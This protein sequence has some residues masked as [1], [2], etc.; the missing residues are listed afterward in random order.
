MSETWI[1]RMPIADNG[2]LDALRLRPEIDV[3]EDGETLWLRMTLG[4]DSK[5]LS[6]LLRSLPGKHY[7]LRNACELI[8]FGRRTPDGSLPLLPWTKLQDW[9]Q[10]ELPTT[11]FS[12]QITGLVDLR[13]VRSAVERDARL[14]MTTIEAWQ[15]YVESAPQIRLTPLSF[16]MNGKTHVLVRGIPLPPIPGQRF[17]FEGNI[18]LPLG[19]R[20]EPDIDP[21][22][23]VERLELSN[24]DM[25]VFQ[26]SGMW[27]HVR[28]DEFVHA[29]RAAA[30][31]SCR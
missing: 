1:V 21:E 14:L 19:Y 20:F 2:S 28:A 29:T 23:V 24:G 3:A 30:R 7:H 25:A 26:Q 5:S 15:A 12:G 16:A 31:A 22:V 13:L 6:Q 18:A 8:P 4:E 10:I 11:Q 9:L 27:Q 17:S